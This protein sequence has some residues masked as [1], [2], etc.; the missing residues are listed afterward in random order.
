MREPNK[1]PKQGTHFVGEF[2]VTSGK[3]GIW[4]PCYGDGDRHDAENGKWLAY[5]DV[6]EFP[7]W[8]RRVWRFRAWQKNRKTLEPREYAGMADVDSGQMGIYDCRDDL[9]TSEVDYDR[10]CDLTLRNEMAGVTE[11]GAVSSSGIGDGSYEYTVCRDP[12]TGK[13]TEIEITFMPE[14]DDETEA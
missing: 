10:I 14:E 6:G 2:D 12:G 7:M 13:V 1:L 4:D 9:D 3:I 11:Y 5:I 8:G